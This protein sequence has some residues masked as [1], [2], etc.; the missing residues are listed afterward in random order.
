MIRHILHVASF[1]ICGMVHT[2]CALGT[3]GSFGW[4]IT[5]TVCNDVCISIVFM[6][7]FITYITIDIFAAMH[8]LWRETILDYYR[9]QQCGN[10]EHVKTL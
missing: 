1:G 10:E 3:I 5:N 9:A 7:W 8:E 6:L 4:L 2:Y